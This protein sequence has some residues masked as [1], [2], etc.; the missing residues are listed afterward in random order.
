MNDWLLDKFVPLRRE[1]AERGMMRDFCRALRAAVSPD[2]SLSLFEAIEASTP[3][4]WQAARARAEGRTAQ[5]NLNA[6]S[7]TAASA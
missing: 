4:D 3:E 7:P 1:L 5:M 6:V 2:G